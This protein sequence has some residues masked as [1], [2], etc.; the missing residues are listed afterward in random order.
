MRKI[1]NTEGACIP[2]QHYMVDISGKLAEI[3]KMVDRGAYF[4]INQARQYGKTTTIHALE[5]YL[6]EYIVVSIDFQSLGDAKFKTEH[7]FSKAFMKQFLLALPIED[8][9]SDVISEIKENTKDEDYELMELFLDLNAICKILPKMIVLIIDEVDSATNNQVFIDFLA[10]IRSYYLKRN[11][12]TTFKSVI[13]SGVYDIRNIK[14]K[15][16]SEED[17]KTNSPWN[18]AA[19]FKVDMSFSPSEIATMLVEYKNDCSYDFDVVKLSGIIYDFTSGYPVL[20][21]R[22]CKLIDENEDGQILDECGI[23]YAVKK[24]LSE[25]DSALFESLTRKLELYPDLLARLDAVLFRGVKQT[26]DKYDNDVALA[27]RFG[28]IKNEN[29]YIAVANRIFETFLY[30]LFLGYRNNNKDKSFVEVYFDRNQF[31]EHGHLNMELVLEKFVKHFDEVYGDQPRKFLEEAGRRY[32]LLY[33]RPIINGTGNYYIESRT[34]NLE[35]TD[36]I[37]DYNGK[38]Y[39]VELKIWHGD[40]YNERGEQQLSNYLDYYGIKKGYMLSF[41]FNKNKEIGLKTVKVQ[42]KI[43]I[44]AVV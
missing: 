23:N 14:R 21:S 31:V 9:I 18:I 20:V 30:N 24:I 2:D 22:I 6:D 7:I 26:Y 42:D 39:I 36:V 29:G 3:K 28:F 32:F 34:R 35:R 15:I 37:I 33:L 43:I 25:D 19:D 16:R 10:Q 11:Q 8:N 40:S 12:I 4:T 1:F 5:K 17:H 13:L 44:E 41:N 38:Q 27:T